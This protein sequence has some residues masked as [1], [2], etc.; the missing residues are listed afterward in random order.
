MVLL[1]VVTHLY[2]IWLTLLYKQSF[3]VILITL[4][5]QSVTSEFMLVPLP[6]FFQTVLALIVNTIF[7]AQ[8][9]AEL[10]LVVTQ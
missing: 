4:Q 5:T 7:G 1:G 3:S 2:F 6:M 10:P 8:I 9:G